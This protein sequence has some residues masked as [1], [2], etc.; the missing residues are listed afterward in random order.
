[1]IHRS[2]AP[3]RRTARGRVGKAGQPG[4]ALP[5]RV[6]ARGIVT[7]FIVATHDLIA[8]LPT[9]REDID[10]YARI[11]ATLDGIL[12]I[13]KDMNALTPE[14]HRGSDFQELIQAVRA[15]LTE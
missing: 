2:S 3:G 9:I 11:R 14:I 12:G 1:M 13:L 7:R 10:L 4:G 8:Y 15:R 5:L 6:H